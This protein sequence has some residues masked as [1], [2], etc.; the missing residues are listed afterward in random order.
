L[1]DKKKQKVISQWYIEAHATYR[2]YV[3]PFRYLPI[4]YGRTQCVQ[5]VF[6]RSTLITR[7]SHIVTQSEILGLIL[8]I[9]FIINL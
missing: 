8:P 9:K 1:A 5:N 3:F 2:Y 6:K 4:N 7:S